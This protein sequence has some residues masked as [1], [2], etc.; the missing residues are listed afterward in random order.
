[1]IFGAGQAGRMI[2]KSLPADCVLTAYIDNNRALQGTVIVK[3]GKVGPEDFKLSQAMAGGRTRS[4]S[5]SS[6]AKPV[7]GLKN[8]SGK[9][10]FPV[11][12]T[13]SMK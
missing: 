2:A 6:T 3:E 4:G 5:R 13:P 12:F 1:M 8:R 11:R 9:R 7:P 10:A